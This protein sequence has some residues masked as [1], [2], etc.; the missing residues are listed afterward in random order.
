MKIQ[1][2]S[3]HVPTKG[4]VN[5]CKFCVS[6][7]HESPYEDRIGQVYNDRDEPTF[8]SDDKGFITEEYKRGILFCKEN[9]VNT[10]ILTGDGEALQN[11]RF[12]E[13]FGKQNNKWGFQWVEL[14]TSGVMLVKYSSDGKQIDTSTLDF[15]RRK[16]GVST[17]SLSVSDLFNNENNYKIQNT[18]EKLRFPIDIICKR[19]KKLN[20]NL[21][22]SLNLNSAFNDHHPADIFGRLKILGADQVTFRKL[23]TSPSGNGDIPQNN[24]IENNPYN[25]KMFENIQEAVKKEGKFLG[26]LPFGAAKYSIQG[27]STVVDDNCMDDA[28][29][30]PEPDVYK[31]LILRPNCKLYSSWDDQGSL[32]F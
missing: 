2:L 23:Y 22:I 31:Y 1:S 10:V 9:G 18:P 11:R 24:W 26:I 14:Q 28:H 6:R 12:L 8:A 21:R 4:C 29:E 25:E 20:F 17:I 30:R 5:N 32:I 19:I 16:V 3:I 15:L 13:Y 7:M 27:I